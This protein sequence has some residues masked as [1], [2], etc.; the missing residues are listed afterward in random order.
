MSHLKEVFSS[1]GWF[2][3]FRVR[4]AR[5]TQKCI[6]MVREPVATVHDNW[7]EL[8]VFLKLYVQTF[9]V[10]VYLC[11]VA[12]RSVWRCFITENARHCA[13]VLPKS[14]NSETHKKLIQKWK[15]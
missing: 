6:K 8:S 15:A 10:H 9:W 5:D 13:S 12:K 2:K 3:K 4:T 7:C 11:Y 1:F 14:L